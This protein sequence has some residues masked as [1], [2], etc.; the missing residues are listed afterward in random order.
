MRTPPYVIALLFA[1]VKKVK[2][3]CYETE[4][5]DPIA[6]C[7]CHES[8]GTCGY[9]FS[10]T[11]DSE[12]ITCADGQ[13][14]ELYPEYDDGTG[15]CKVPGVQ[16]CYEYEGAETPIEGCECDITCG[17][18]G[19]GYTEN[20]DGDDP[21]YPWNCIDCADGLVLYNTYEDGTGTCRIPGPENCLAEVGDET[22]IEGCMCHETC[23]TSCGYNK[24]PGEPFEEWPDY[25]YDCMDCPD[26]LELFAVWDDGTGYCLEPSICYD[27]VSGE[28]S[29]ACTCEDN[30]A[31][32]LGDA[33]LGTEN[34]GVC[35]DEYYGELVETNAEFE[36]G[37]CVDFDMDAYYEEY[38]AYYLEI[39]EEYYGEEDEDD[40][41]S[42][43]TIQ[44]GLAAVTMAVMLQL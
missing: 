19:C 42:A 20:E 1:S 24:F 36:T 17:T 32:C 29:E 30:C 33:D 25:E 31:A 34:C 23:G 37:Y 11:W 6:D 8:C 40:E 43:T 16:A 44:T 39:W 3:N 4:G 21:T 28:P 10:P 13:G 35:K 7:T 15:Y 9:N 27:P 26:G 38:Y 22:P 18:A 41:A 12:C 14:L 2:A 5:A